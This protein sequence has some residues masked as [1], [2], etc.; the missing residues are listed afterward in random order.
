MALQSAFPLPNITATPGSYMRDCRRRAGVT[1]AQCAEAI[2][3][4]HHDR[5]R[6]AH[7][8]RALERDSPGDYGNLVRHLQARAPFPFD[9]GHFSRLAAATCA[10]ELDE[11][12]EI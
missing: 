10:P 7:D 12:A 3:L 4:Q 8:L 11:F 6:A 2:S 9:A 5:H 1:I